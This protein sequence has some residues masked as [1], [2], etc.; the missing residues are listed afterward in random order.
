M[1]AINYQ[2]K[3]DINTMANF[4][5]FRENGKS[6]YVLK[7]EYL[8]LDNARPSPAVRLLVHVIS[9]QQLPKPQA[10]QGGE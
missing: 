1:V 7:P 10:A 5:R 2:T 3:L 8:R 9:A 6:G 4:G